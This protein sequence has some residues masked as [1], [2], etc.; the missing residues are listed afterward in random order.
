V[1]KIFPLS[2]SDEEKLKRQQN[3]RLIEQVIDQL[4]LEIVDSNQPFSARFKA[5]DSCTYCPFTSF[6]GQ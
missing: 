3:F 1:E 5:E 4:L 6:C 2:E